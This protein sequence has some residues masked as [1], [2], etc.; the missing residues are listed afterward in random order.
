M[1]FSKTNALLTH[2]L[3]S[4]WRKQSCCI[5]ISK[6]STAAR[7]FKYKRCVSVWYYTIAHDYTWNYCTKSNLLN[8]QGYL[9]YKAQL[10]IFQKIISKIE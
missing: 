1:L 2:T 6:H 4:F 8:T 3:A 9:I 7:V 5:M 10:M